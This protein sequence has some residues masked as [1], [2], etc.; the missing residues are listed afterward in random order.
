[1]TSAVVGQAW[2]RDPPPFHI[3]RQVNLPDKKFF[4]L[5]QQKGV[6]RFIIY[7]WIVLDFTMAFT[8]TL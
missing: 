3:G 7:P 4:M 2:L 6:K 5:I 8:F 1:M